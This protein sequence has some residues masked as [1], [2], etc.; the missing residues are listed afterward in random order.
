MPPELWIHSYSYI[1]LNP[2]IEDQ[3]LLLV[4][5][6]QCTYHWSGDDDTKIVGNGTKTAEIDK[7]P[8]ECKVVDRMKF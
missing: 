8:Q 1:D 7:E 5:N 4:K 3:F 2:N 6:N